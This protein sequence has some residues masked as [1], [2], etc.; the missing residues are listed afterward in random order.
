VCQEIG[1]GIFPLFYKILLLLKKIYII[2][3]SIN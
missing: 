1:G 2:Y 3:N